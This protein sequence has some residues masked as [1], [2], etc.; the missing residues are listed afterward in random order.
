MPTDF[1]TANSRVRRMM[2]FASVLNT[3]AT[4]MRAMMRE[5]HITN[6][7]MACVV[8][9]SRRAPSARS[10]TKNETPSIP[11]ASA[12]SSSAAFA[13]SAALKEKLANEYVKG[14]AKRSSAGVAAALS[15]RMSAGNWLLAPRALSTSGSPSASA[16]TSIPTPV[17]TS[18]RGR[19]SMRSGSSVSR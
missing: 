4:A 1:S 13:W 19:A 2:L 12:S 16:P 14:L 11:S 8:R 17:A 6:S 15:S 5:K 3:F 18:S 7:W 10:V 9:R